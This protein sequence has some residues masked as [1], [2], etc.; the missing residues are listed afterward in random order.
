[1]SEQMSEQNTPAKRYSAAM[2]SVRLVN[3]RVIAGADNQ[4]QDERRSEID[5]NVEHLKI[6]VTWDIWTTEDLSPL[7]LAISTGSN[8]L[9]RN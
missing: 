3:D 7:N 9:S 8:W 4:T 5:R 2:D 1:M 6:A